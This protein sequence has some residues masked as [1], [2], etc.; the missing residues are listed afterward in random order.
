MSSFRVV[1]YLLRR[2]TPNGDILLNLLEFPCLCG[3]IESCRISV[4]YPKQNGAL[5]H[6]EIKIMM[7]VYQTVLANISPN[8]NVFWVVLTLAKSRKID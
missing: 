2:H 6:L 1:T 8:Y 4:R 7:D 3:T 5:Q